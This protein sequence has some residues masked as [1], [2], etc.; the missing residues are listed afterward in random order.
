MPPS[1]INCDNC[2]AANRPQAAFCGCCGKSLTLAGGQANTFATWLLAPHHLLKQRYCI[3]GRLGRGGM[4]AV[5]KVEDLQFSNRLMAL[6]EMKQTG[7]DAQEVAEAAEQF[8]HEAILLASLKHP[9]L[10][11]TPGQKYL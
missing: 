1:T 3:V 2:G 11:S 6:K 5:Y 9:S 10:P 4:G 7:L 8:K